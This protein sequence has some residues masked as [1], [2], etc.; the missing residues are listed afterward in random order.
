VQAMTPKQKQTIM[1]FYTVKAKINGEVQNL[2]SGYS[3]SEARR[4]STNHDKTIP[5][6]G[7]DSW[8]FNN[9][10]ERVTI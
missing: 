3:L 8:I 10:T 5:F 1:T 4:V 9:E 6:G 7:D 2:W